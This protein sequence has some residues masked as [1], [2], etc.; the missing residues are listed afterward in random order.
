[1][2]RFIMKRIVTA[3]L[4]LLATAAH[5]GA[6]QLVT[7]Q[8]AALPPDEALEFV[9]R[10]SPTR[11]PAVVVISPAQNAG[12]V[13]SPVS[14]KIRFQAF[15]GAKINSESVVMTYMRKPAINL[16]QR[17]RS[18]IRNDGIDVPDAEL[19]PGA[20]AFRIEVRDTDGRAGGGIFTIQVAN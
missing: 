3:W 5:A 14:L 4:A 2:R 15:G 20:H 9:L 18:F 19:P 12:L 7:A 17:V 6:F 10:G 8:E 13:T 11:R 16:T 1:L